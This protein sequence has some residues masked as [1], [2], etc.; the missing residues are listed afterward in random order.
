MTGKRDK[1][2]HGGS[3]QRRAAALRAHANASRYTRCGRCGLTYDE[4]AIIH[5]EAAARWEAGHV[6]DSQVN[7][8]L[9]P[10]HSRCNRSAGASYG[11]RL[12][13]PHSEIWY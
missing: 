8:A 1:P 2:W 12:R 9:Q 5:G 10:E 13:E 6:V 4:Y 3:Y 11:N 7:G